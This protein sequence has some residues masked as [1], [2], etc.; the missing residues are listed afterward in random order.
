MSAI[1][2]AVYRGNEPVLH[3][4]GT[5]DAAQKLAPAT[6]IRLRAYTDPAVAL[7]NLFGDYARRSQRHPWSEPVEAELIE[8]P[9]VLE[10]TASPEGERGRPAGPSLHQSAVPILPDGRS[11]AMASHLGRE[12]VASADRDLAGDTAGPDPFNDFALASLLAGY[13]PQPSGGL[14]NLLA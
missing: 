2:A 6:G 12:E 11:A 13:L 3:G 8:R 9:P 5:G 4:Y 7:N 14:V 10:H 1:A